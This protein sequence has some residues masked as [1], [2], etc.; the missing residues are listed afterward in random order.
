M[1]DRLGT[2]ELGKLA[3]IVLVNLDSVHMVPNNNYVSDLI[4]AGCGAD[5]DTVIIDGEIIMEQRN[6]KT[7]N[8][9]EIIQQA[10]ERASALLERTHV[11]PINV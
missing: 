10:R 2:L 9:Q 5:V 4:Y 1:Q 11:K 7:L 6:V 8:E 3:D